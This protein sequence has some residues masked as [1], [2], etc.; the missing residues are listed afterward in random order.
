MVK[1]TFFE[2]NHIYK[3]VF[4]T[5]YRSTVVFPEFES[6]HSTTTYIRRT[7]SEFGQ[8]ALMS[9]F[10]ESLLSLHRDFVKVFQ[11]YQ[12]N[13]EEKGFLHVAFFILNSRN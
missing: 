12:N 5:T 4:T 9:I 3:G 13:A 11:I 1:S 10:E 6:S 2:E 7:A 8:E